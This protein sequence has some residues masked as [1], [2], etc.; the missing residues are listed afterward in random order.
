MAE[1]SDVGAFL[2]LD[3]RYAELNGQFSADRESVHAEAGLAT[4]RVEVRLHKGVEG[5]GGGGVEPIV[6]EMRV[7]KVGWMGKA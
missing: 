5:G 7:W 2:A 4:V 1:A 6:G 3:W